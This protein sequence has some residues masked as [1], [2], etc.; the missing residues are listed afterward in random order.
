MGRKRSLLALS[1]KVIFDHVFELFNKFKY[2]RFK[3]EEVNKTF[4]GEFLHYQKIAS[5]SPN[6]R[7]GNARGNIKVNSLKGAMGR[8]SGR[9]F[10]NLPLHFRLCARIAK[11]LNGDLMSLPKGFNKRTTQ[12]RI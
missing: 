10:P 1:R 12:V 9:P 7:D 2:L 3:A 4:S 11:T 8:T 5:N 6:A